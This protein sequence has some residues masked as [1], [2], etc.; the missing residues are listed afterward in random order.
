MK[1]LVLTTFFI[2]AIC[3]FSTP[4]KTE[5]AS[6]PTISVTGPAGV[7]DL[8]ELAEYTATVGTEADSY[9]VEF[10]W[11]TS[12]GEIKEGQGT[13]SIKVIQPNACITVTLEIRG[14]PA[15]CPSAASETACGDPPPMAEKV[16]ELA[17]SQAITKLDIQRIVE[18]LKNYP[19]NQLYILAGDVQRKNS[20]SFQ[21]KWKTIGR[22]LIRGGIQRE[23]IT[24]VYTATEVSQF[25]R[26]PP[27]A[28]NPAP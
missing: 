13:R 14:L 11:T 12:V 21:K 20:S 27:G 9:P 18:T 3:S 26:V 28:S 1:K 19:N 24:I 2:L 15:S 5:P 10:V 17:A 25:W 4:Q 6:C 8:G 7:L 22:L 23:R 16:G